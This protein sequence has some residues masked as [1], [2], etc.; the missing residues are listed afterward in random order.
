MATALV[1][2]GSN[3][4]DRAAALLRSMEL[5]KEEPRI[6]VDAV[7]SFR[8]CKP[9]GGPEGQSEFLN[10]AARLE[11]SLSPEELLAKLQVLEDQIGRV[12]EERWGP[13]VIDLDLLLYDQVEMKTATLELPHPQMC[14]RRF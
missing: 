6:R 14:Y 3:L 7:S 12:R 13:R 11:T 10:A 4:G 9:A 5:L 2:L 1:G 8:Q